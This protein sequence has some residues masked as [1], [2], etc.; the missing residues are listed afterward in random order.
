MNRWN[1]VD[2]VTYALLVR[3]YVVYNIWA[4]HKSEK[5]YDCWLQPSPTGSWAC[6]FDRILFADSNQPICSKYKW[7]CQKYWKISERDTLCHSHT[8]SYSTHLETHT[9]TH[10][11][12]RHTAC[13][14]Y[15]YNC[16]MRKYVCWAKLNIVFAH[17]LATRFNRG[18]A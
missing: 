12:I 6:T 3:I 8:S 14:V 2:C 18:H 7:K 17:L 10:S 5:W 16:M 4:Y 13:A 1:T 11:H 9:H 15:G